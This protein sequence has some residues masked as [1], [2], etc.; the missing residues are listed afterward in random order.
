MKQYRAA[1]VHGAHSR[2]RSANERGDRFVIVRLPNDTGS[3]Y[4]ALRRGE[5]LIE[6]SHETVFEACR[7]L[8]AIGIADQMRPHDARATLENFEDEV[9]I[10][11][12]L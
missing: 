3:I 6:S 4:R 8:L 9:A 2:P 12:S 11:E 7:A 5:V 1:V 10:F